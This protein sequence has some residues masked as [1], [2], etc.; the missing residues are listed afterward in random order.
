MAA[1]QAS[2]LPVPVAPRRLTA[3]AILL[4]E[5]IDTVGLERS[6]MISTNPLAFRV[7][8]AGEV[9]L[10]RFGVAVLFALSPVEEDEVLRGLRPRITA[11]FKRNE[12]ETVRSRS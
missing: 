10:F 12:D 7:G 1:P 2:A 3:R 6:E 11:P 9:V 5:R 4:G 8:A